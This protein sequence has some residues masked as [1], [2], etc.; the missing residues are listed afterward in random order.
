[1]GG[2]HSATAL[3][4]L[5]RTISTQAECFGGPGRPS[6]HGRRKAMHTLDGG[7]G[8]AGWS[9]DLALLW[10]IAAMIWQYCV[11]GGR[12]RRAYRRK[13]ARGETYWV[14]AAGPTHHREEAARPR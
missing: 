8:T 11:P 13:E 14:D 3:N 7:G 12:L 10:R 5:S 4:V 6:Y 2:S 9:R 1:M